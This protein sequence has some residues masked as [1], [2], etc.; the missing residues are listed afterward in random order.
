VADMTPKRTHAPVGTEKSVPVLFSL[1]NVQPLILHGTN[2]LPTNQKSSNE[3]NG[4]SVSSDSIEVVQ[5][6]AKA[7]PTTSQPQLASRFSYI[8]NV[9]A[10]TLVVLLILFV[11]KLSIPEKKGDSQGADFEVATLPASSLQNQNISASVPIPAPSPP[12]VSPL[13]SN[14]VSSNQ[15]VLQNP[16]VLSAEL[17]PSESRDNPKLLDPPKQDSS[18]I[19]AAPVLLTGTSKSRSDTLDPATATVSKVSGENSLSSLASQ[20][21]VPSLAVSASATPNNVLTPNQ[22]N[23]AKPAI[24]AEQPKLQASVGNARPAETTPQPRSTAAPDLQ[25]MDINDFFAMHEKSKQLD[26]ASGR[27]HRQAIPVT[28]TSTS[29]SGAFSNAPKATP[30][31]PILGDA[32]SPAFLAPP[33]S[34]GNLN[35]VDTGLPPIAPSVP[36]AGQSYPPTNVQDN[37]T[38]VPDYGQPI[39]SSQMNLSNRYQ[40]TVK[41]P[42]TGSGANPSTGISQPKVPYS[43]IG[44]TNTTQPTIIQP[45]GASFGYPPSK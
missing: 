4:S 35:I 43:P 16:S 24:T 18:P 10:T 33:G 9:V 26:S 22:L 31:R 14:R 45:S 12:S 6:S 32:L 27:D 30:Y 25:S 21:S 29:G 1:K 3:S 15:P 36:F 17:T 42:A 7:A 5:P 41:Q 8:Q 13:P 37:L 2:S 19:P 39:T 44:T 38:T 34:A 28:P 23:L 20:E 11:I 40:P